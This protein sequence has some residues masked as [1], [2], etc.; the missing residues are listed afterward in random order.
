M[1]IVD[2]PEKDETASNERIRASVTPANGFPQCSIALRRYAVDVQ[3]ALLAVD[4]NNNNYADIA[5][6][7]IYIYILV[8]V[9]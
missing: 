6:I 2:N 1:M 9:G 5:T 3:H 4:N 7:Y 8:Q